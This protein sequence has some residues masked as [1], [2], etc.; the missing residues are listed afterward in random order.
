MHT[1]FRG[2]LP[3]LLLLL[4]FLAPNVLLARHIIGGEITYKFLSVDN[5]GRYRYRFTM[6]IY[7]DCQGGGAD[8]DDPAEMAIYRGTY[9]N[10]ILQESFKIGNPSIK[11]LIPVP[12]P[13][14]STLPSVC[15]E[16][17][18]YTFERALEV[19]LTDSYF[20]VYQRCCRN[21]TINNI[22]SP[23]D[24]G[25]TYMVELTPK[26]QE[27]KNSSPTFNN[28]PPIIICNSI[29]LEFD[30]SATD[31]EGDQIFYSFCSPFDGG[32][33]LL[34]PPAV[35]T[36]DG[37]VPTPPCAPPFDNVPFIVG[38]YT[39]SNPMGGAPKVSIDNITG[40]IT[41]TPNKLG[42]FVVG[43]CI[44]EF[45]G[46]E[47]L[48]TIRRDFQFNVAECTP[49]VLA[50]IQ[51]DSIV[52]PQQFVLRSCGQNSV[53][54]KNLSA[55]KS[56][57]FSFEWRFDLKGTPYS[58]KTNWDPTVNFP[59]TGLYIGNLYLNPGYPCAD[60]ANIAVNIFPE[61][62][63]DFSFA[64][65]TCVAGPVAFTDLSTSD[66]GIDRWNWNFGVP[67]GTSKVQNPDYLYAVPGSHP[68]Q[69]RVYDKN[70]CTDNEVKVVNWF[71]VPPL[72]IIQP[73]NYIGCSPAEI[74]FNNLSA[75]IDSTYDI[76]W[77]FG[78]GTTLT[79]VI[80][81][82]HIYNTPGVFDVSVDITSPIGC[83]I[84]DAF[85]D[86]IRVVPSPTADFTYSPDSLLSQF[87][88]TIQFTDLSLDANRWH[89]EF[90]RFGSTITRNPLFT[91]PDTG[92]MKVTLIVTHPEGCKDSLSKYLDFVP[93]IK[94]YMPN[95]FTPNGDGQNDGF[96]GK[97]YL[98]GVVDFNMS[99]WN[100]WGEKVYESQD[101][102]EE[103]N[104]RQMNK[105][106]MSP[107]GVYVY[108]VTF[109]SP[110]G[111]KQEFKGYATLLR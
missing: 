96:L 104:G 110:R 17:A 28:F 12:P 19:S 34:S 100:R 75:P 7:R 26:A 66:A 14:I 22:V 58:D 25:A 40:L 77:D 51:S 3:V 101:P 53:T 82:T 6:K 92:L 73:S 8:F 16:E 23:G 93:V 72:I 86:L 54:F 39:A 80:S 69:L 111:Q 46:A 98:D 107:E 64:Y 33:P 9:S 67:N 45:R 74:F 62:K 44:Q 31:P 60:T 10:N 50:N 13:C 105:G 108:L 27:L 42:Q 79:G 84:S 35:T 88:N 68:V 59:D 76:V 56:N 63:A 57:I 78:D 81:P 18:I 36:C 21:Q 4:A 11:K 85:P 89:W 30:H 24:V 61:I 15:V 38:Q 37:A 94:W 71:P 102:Q 90:D 106:G 83:R 97:G 99:I 87:N 20:I 52:G 65:D 48:S 47:L 55:Q 43:V 41:G 91:F 5:Q 1:K 95:A 2:L 103:W 70:K 32:G 109:T 49:S 29:P